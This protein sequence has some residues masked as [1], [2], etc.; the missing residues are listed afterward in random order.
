MRISGLVCIMIANY[1]SF[2]DSYML[3][4]ACSQDT[5][6]S[7]LE[8]WPCI[9]CNGTQNV[10]N[11]LILT[12]GSCRAVFP[13]DLISHDHS[14]CNVTN[15]GKYK[16]YC[17]ILNTI[18][19]ICFIVGFY[20]TIIVILGKINSIMQAENVRQISRKSINSIAFILLFVPIFTFFF[21]EP[22]V[23]NIL[24]M[25]Y[26]ISATMIYCCIDSPKRIQEIKNYVERE[27][28]KEYDPIND[29]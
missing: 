24:F 20:L 10:S 16:T 7:C 1:L 25:T 17:N 22:Y 27:R 8:S 5:V 19:Y 4:E 21:L 14:H 13:C 18:A 11:K 3:K 23:F 15:I 28:H 29:D 26:I 6:D 9:W 12:N 2:I